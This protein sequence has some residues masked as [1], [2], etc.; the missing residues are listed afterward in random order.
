ML[1]TFFSL[2]ILASAASSLR[3][4]SPELQKAA[5]SGG[6][7]PCSATGTVAGSSGGTAT[8]VASSSINVTPNVL[9]TTVVTEDEKKRRLIEQIDWRTFQCKSWHLEPTVR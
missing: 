6:V 3:T 2:Q 1:V 5:A 4:Q 9:S 8:D 7:A